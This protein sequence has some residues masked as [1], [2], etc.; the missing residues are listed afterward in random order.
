VV[1]ARALC[2]LALGLGIALGSVRHDAPAPEPMHAGGYVVLAADFHVH[3]WPDGIPPWD[4]VREAA[5][6]RLDV[7][8]LTSHN[9]M[10]GWR[11]WT[12]A[13]WRPETHVLVLPGEELTSVG[14]HMALVG[15]HETVRW[16]Q[17]AASAAAAAHAQGAI[18]ILAHPAGMAFRR[19]VTDADLA[20]VDGIEVAHPETLRR[21][22]FRA[23]YQRALALK[24]T[25]AAIGSSD[26]HYF[27]PIGLSRTYV[28]ALA[29]TSEGVLD[30]IRAG[31]TVACD[32]A[33]ETTGPP[34]LARVVDE[35]CHA[36]ATLPP[37]GDNAFARAG[38]VLSWSALAALVLL[39]A[40][41]E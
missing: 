39:G 30:A 11:L 25:I 16:R 14:Y 18:A 6:R 20:A 19:L 33:G 34:A 37:L 23:A 9:A 3:G 10:T 1:K 28:F 32:G 7:V 27:A 24:P 2:V 13:P 26:F 21:Q 31:R 35:R 15:I 36:D 41:D 17:R 40:S 8:A 29:A 38:A 12:D 22:R 4:A 5:R